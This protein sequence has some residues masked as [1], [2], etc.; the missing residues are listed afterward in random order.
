MRDKIP[1]IQYILEN[2]PLENDGI[3]NFYYYQALAAFAK[4][5]KKITFSKYNFKFLIK[6]QFQLFVD[7]LY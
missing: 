2:G 5:I 3:A 6:P 4:T 7:Q 1:P